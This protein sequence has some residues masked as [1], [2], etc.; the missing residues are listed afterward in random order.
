MTRERRNDIVIFSAIKPSLCLPLRAKA[1][2]EKWLSR[3]KRRRE[4]RG[5]RQ[6]PH[7]R[8]GRYYLF[9]SFSPFSSSNGLGVVPDI[10]FC[11]SARRKPRRPRRPHRRRC[12]CRLRLLLLLLLLHLFLPFTLRLLVSLP[13]S[14]RSSLGPLF[15]LAA[16]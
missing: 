16:L 12:R 10:S 2:G 3:M 15:P 14:Y 9:L 6:I 13:S 7:P 11:A 8:T 4:E 5:E 1:G